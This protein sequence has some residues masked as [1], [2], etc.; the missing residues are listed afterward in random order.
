MAA[1]FT[2][3]E[4]DIM[5]V[6]WRLG[7]ATASEA[8]AELDDQLAYNSVLTMLRILEDKGHVRHEEEGRAFRYFPLV[9]RQDAKAGAVRRLID[10]LFDG[11][12]ALLATQLVNGR[13][14]S[15]DDLRDLRS[16]LDERLKS[17]QGK[18][19]T[20]KTRRK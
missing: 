3:R 1:Q 13:A 6:L 2:D 19:T 14:L 9:A 18:T 17:R 16:L 10:R 8:R 5:D 15:D 4:L 11:E 7:S 12:P 20:P